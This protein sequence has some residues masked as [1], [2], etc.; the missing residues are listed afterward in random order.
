MEAQGS[1][2]N[3]INSTAAEKQRHGNVKMWK[4]NHFSAALKVL[5]VCYI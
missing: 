2:S 5:G 1:K 3:W 4:K